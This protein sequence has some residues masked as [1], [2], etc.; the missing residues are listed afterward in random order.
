MTGTAWKALGAEGVPV[1]HL[2]ASVAGR[3]LEDL[4]CSGSRK[5][6][7]ASRVEVLVRGSSCFSLS[8]EQNPFEGFIF[9]NY[10]PG[11]GWTG[12]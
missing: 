3:L 12:S 1:Y 8:H 4:F 9:P 2:A 10:P 6:S 7:V 5:I 11:T